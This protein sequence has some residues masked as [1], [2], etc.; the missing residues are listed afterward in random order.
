[1]SGNTV[2]II[3]NTYDTP[4]VKSKNINRIPGTY[5]TLI[6]NLALYTIRTKINGINPN[7]VFTNAVNT[8][9]N[10]NNSLGNFVLNKKSLLSFKQVTEVVVAA[11]KHSYKRNPAK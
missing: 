10:T 4:I 11:L 5:T 7:N 1:M 9:D 2:Y 8:L 3:D 6:V